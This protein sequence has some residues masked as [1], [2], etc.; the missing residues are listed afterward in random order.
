MR[1]GGA[2]A[3][4]PF[5]AEALALA[6]TDTELKAWWQAQQEFDRRMTAKL[7]EVPVPKRLRHEILLGPKVVAMPTAEHE[8]LPCAR[9][10]FVPPV[11][12]SGRR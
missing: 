6:E 8:V 9:P 1:P 12:N 2:E 7:R 3:N 5:F 4:E 11:T 10:S